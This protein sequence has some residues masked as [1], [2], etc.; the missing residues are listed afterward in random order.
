M[1]KAFSEK[2]LK[3]IPSTFGPKGSKRGFETTFFEPLSAL[4]EILFFWGKFL[5]TE[6]TTI[7]TADRIYIRINTSAII[8]SLSLCL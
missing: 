2:R 7:L 3:M 1:T 5:F 8:L 6:T 4:R